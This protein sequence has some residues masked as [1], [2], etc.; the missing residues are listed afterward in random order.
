MQTHSPEGIFTE[1]FR[2]RVH[3]TPQQNWMNDPNGLLY[4]KGKYH[5]FYQHNPSGILWGNMS[6]G[7]AESSDLFT[8]EHLPVAI[9]CTDTTGMFSGSAVV[10]H[11]N[12]SG[13]GSLENPP[14]VA[15]YTVHFNDE[16][17]QSQH[18]AYSLDEGVTWV[19]YADNPVLDLGMKDFRDPK[20]T[21]ESSTQTWLMTVAK[22]QEFKIA[23]FRSKDLKNWSHLSD[24]GPLGAVSGIWECPDLFP[25]P[26]PSGETKWVLIVSLNPGGIT[27]GSGTQFFIGDWDGTHFT[28]DQDAIKWI[29]Y[30]RDNYAGVTFNDAP[31][32]RRIF[33]GWMCNWDYAS[34]LP[35]PIWRTS[36]TTPREL[37]LQEVNGQ[38]LL[39]T[40]P[41]AELRAPV[42][43]SFLISSDKNALV[44][45]GKAPHQ[46]AIS[47]DATTK[48]ISIDRSNA[49]F[50]DIAD[51]PQLSPAIELQEFTIRVVIDH[52]S[53]ELF[54]PEAGL[55]MTSLH[56][57]PAARPV[58]QN[59][60]N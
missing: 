27:G 28:S 39:T 36:M 29:D 2:P 11:T 9:A 31:D 53:L 44:T 32:N 47:F 22:P 49:W 51:G 58:L 26:T 13:F 35:S 40:H 5:L 4:Y 41:I 30:G 42:D 16:S 6:W 34:K 21:W 48:R 1:E 20:V 19:K 54:I 7:H 56:T 50:E 43:E 33:L 10:D 25:L 45:L 60:A 17:N 24:F 55:A 37:A 23:F 3:F 18:I 57:L 15:I 12:S 52:G 38:L 14:M 8:W 46:L 59:P